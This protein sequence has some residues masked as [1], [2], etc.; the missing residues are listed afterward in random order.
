MFF[1]YILGEPPKQNDFV[2]SDNFSEN[3]FLL[4]T[5]IN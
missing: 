2:L 4:C 3:V 1:V 5:R